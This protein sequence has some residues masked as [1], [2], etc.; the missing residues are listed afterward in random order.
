MMKVRRY[1]AVVCALGVATGLIFSAPVA[2]AVP[3]D[4]SVTIANTDMGDGPVFV[5]PQGSAVIGPAVID[6]GTLI[7]DL[8]DLRVVLDTVALL[9]Q[10]TAPFGVRG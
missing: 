8:G 9:A 10:I 4:D 6:I 5:F 7:A 3:S 2:S 1:V